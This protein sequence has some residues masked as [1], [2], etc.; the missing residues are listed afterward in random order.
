MPLGRWDR[1]Q[2]NKRNQNHHLIFLSKQL[3]VAMLNSFLLK[4]VAA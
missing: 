2:I 1:E 4:A 3:H